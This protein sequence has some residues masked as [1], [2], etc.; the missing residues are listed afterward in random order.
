MFERTKSLY[1]D[2]RAAGFQHRFFKRYEQSMA[3][4]REHRNEAIT[5]A[6]V[7]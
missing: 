3:L 2:A 4:Y 5:R 6:P 7:L 1:E